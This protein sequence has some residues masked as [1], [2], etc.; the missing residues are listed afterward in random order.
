MSLTHIETIEL[1]SSQSSITFS[2]IPQD[3]DDLVVLIAARTTRNATGDN[4]QFSFNG[5]S[6]NFTAIR[7]IGN[8]GSVL[9]FGNAV[10]YIGEAPSAN[11]TADTFGNTQVYI[12]NY[13]SSNNKSYSVDD[14]AE[15]NGS[16]GHTTLTAGLWSVSTA[17]SSI[18]IFSE[19]SSSLVSG[20]TFSLYGVTA[21]GDG[22]VT[23]S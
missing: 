10:S 4:L 1:T 15:N 6:S 14:T 21:G 13:A 12:S 22:T 17:I 11:N 20:S 23:T 5:S 18:G 19:T 8:G 2:S 3:Y 7:L 9:T 16:T